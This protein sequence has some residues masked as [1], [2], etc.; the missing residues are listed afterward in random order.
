VAEVKKTKKYQDLL[1]THHF[2]PLAM[3]TLGPINETGLTFVADIGRLL[4][5][6]TDEARETSFIFQRTSVTIQR[7][8][9]VAFAGTFTAPL[10]E[11]EQRLFDRRLHH[12]RYTCRPSFV[13][14]GNQSESPRCHDSLSPIANLTNSA[15]ASCP[16]NP[17]AIQVLVD[18]T[19]DSVHDREI[20]HTCGS[21]RESVADV[22][23]SESG[24]EEDS[25]PPKVIEPR[26]RRNLHVLHPTGPNPTDE[27]RRL[28]H[29]LP[30]DCPKR[31]D[32]AARADQS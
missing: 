24:E 8:N 30:P 3:E 14:R 10:S 29:G 28:R 21:T 2:I 15:C 22:R 16:P 6:A 27:P 13:N 1:K 18:A 19:R 12:S 20:G 23:H 5:Q 17:P 9:A 31:P 4:T 7:F 26:L 11:F 25:H 32:R